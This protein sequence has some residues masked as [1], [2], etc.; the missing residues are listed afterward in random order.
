MPRAGSAKATSAYR[1][2]VFQFRAATLELAK[3]GT[4]IRL[5]PQPARLL[6]LLLM[7]P[8]ELVTRGTIRELLWKDGTNVDFETGVNRC[9][10]Q[11]RTAL[12][13]DAVTPRYIKTVA[14][15]G[16]SFIA[17][18]G[19]GATTPTAAPEFSNRAPANS[20]AVLPF[21]NLSGDPQDEYFSD[22]LTEEITN[23]L[24]QIAGLRVL[25]RTSAFAFKGKNDDIRRIAAALDVDNVL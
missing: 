10:R 21:A 13:D 12:C 11:L 2:G 23:V 5:Q 1:F 19:G 24:A 15:I 4:P 16:Y 25:A 8:G 22:G 20:I 9:I 17:P 3:N 7:N 14:R 18:V 6:N